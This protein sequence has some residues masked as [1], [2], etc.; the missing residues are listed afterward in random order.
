MS[1]AKPLIKVSKLK[2]HYT[3]GEHT[4]KALDGVDLEIMPG[5]FVMIVGSSGSGKSTLMHILGLLDKPTDGSF[6]LGNQEVS[7]LSDDEYAALRNQ[8]IGFVFQQ[9]NLLNELTVVENVALPLAYSGV[10]KAERIDKASK[11]ATMTGLEERL[12]HRPTQL[13][14]GQ[15]QRIA[16]ARALVNN[17]DI[18][19]ADEPTGA[20]DSKTG[21]EIMDLLHELNDQGHT[22]IMV[23]HDSVLAEQ[24]T[25]KIVV[26]DGHIVDDVRGK[27][28]AKGKMKD[29]K[30]Q[31]LGGLSFLDLFIIGL[32]EGLLPHKMRSFLTMLGIIIGVASVIAMSSFSLGS[33]Q[34]QAD[35]IRAL[36][37][38]LVKVI[39]NRLE[40]ETLL[41]ARRQG[42]AGLNR[43]D[44]SALTANI[45]GIL[46]KS[47]L[48]ESP[49]N[50]L[51]KGEK[52]NARVLGVGGDYLKV[53]N[54]EIGLGRS[55][56]DYDQAKAARV[57]VIGSGLAKRLEV[58][59]PIGQVLL[60]GGFPYKVVG[61]LKNKNIDLKELDASSLKDT[62]FD[63][64]IPF[65]TLQSRTTY[66]QTRSELDEIQLQLA[67]E[68]Q[69]YKVGKSLKRTLANL[70]A[71]VED[72]QIVIPLDL[73]KQKQ[74]SQKL[75]DLLTIIISSISIVVGGI[76][77]MNIMLATV[78]ERIREIGV[79]R[80]VGAT[81]KDILYQFL[82]ESMIISVTGGLFGVLFALIIVIITSQA[83]GL[84]IVFSIPLVGISVAASVVTGLVFGLY[85]ARNAAAMNPVEALKSD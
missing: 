42:S 32:R 62:N 8:R 18:L 46:A 59:N 27:K 49:M 63:V 85:P 69:L 66:L 70:H 81:Q 28:A 67:N 51:Y 68:D 19:M 33:K 78:N 72:Y 38:N 43:K 11:Y 76:G 21:K 12:D 26:K 84:P 47:Y 40:N 73:L 64:L 71:G 53:N 41:Q 65:E 50:V 31:S 60:M 45:D 34:K 7:D 2:R 24:G 6:I 79:R 52:V 61:V 55:L 4:V 1:E 30:I 23:T 17:P 83:I 25:R 82:A 75:L 29:G 22:I 36:G 14:G 5:E 58:K 56:D 16:I 54:H 35:Q 77:I 15:N 44:L 48:R 9:F 3:M 80:A 37:A 10:D 57:A 13:S 20:L 39:D 74:Q